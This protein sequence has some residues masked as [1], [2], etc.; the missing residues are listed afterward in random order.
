MFDRLFLIDMEKYYNFLMKTCL[1]FGAKFL[2]AAGDLFQI[3]G[4]W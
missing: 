2:V 4:S 3:L 1:F